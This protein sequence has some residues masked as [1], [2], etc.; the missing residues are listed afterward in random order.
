MRKTTGMERAY[1]TG[2]HD[3]HIAWETKEREAY[4]KHI[5]KAKDP[6]TKHKCLT[7]A[8]DSMDHSK[9]SLPG[10]ARDDKKTEKGAKLHTHLTGVLIHG[11]TPGAL[12][13]TWHDRFPAGSDVVTTILLDALSRIDGP[14]PPT[15]NLWLDNCWR[16][17]KNK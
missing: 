9:T 14:L 7:I 17:N 6:E 3:K 5:T 16:E 2:V 1:W 11:R 13:F 4:A 8:I 12:C 15:L 10:R